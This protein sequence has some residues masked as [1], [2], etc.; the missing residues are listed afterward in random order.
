MQKETIG[1]DGHISPAEDVIETAE[2]TQSTQAFSPPT[3]TSSP[4]Q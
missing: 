1:E 2:F 4:Q 3:T